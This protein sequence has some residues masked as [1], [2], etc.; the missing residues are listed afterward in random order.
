MPGSSITWSTKK[1]EMNAVVGNSPPN[2]SDARYGPTNGI[3]IAD[4]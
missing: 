4:E 2:A 3:E 1:R